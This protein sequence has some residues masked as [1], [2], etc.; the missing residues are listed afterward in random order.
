MER[1]L[2]FRKRERKRQ[3]EP[4][5]CRK[6]VL[7]SP[8]AKVMS[9]ATGRSRGQGS[10]KPVNLLTCHLPTEAGISRLLKL[11]GASAAEEGGVWPGP[12]LSGDG[13]GSAST[14]PSPC[15]LSGVD[16]G[17]PDSQSRLQEGNDRP[18]LRL[19]VTR[20]PRPTE[21]HEAQWSQRAGHTSPPVTE[22]PLNSTTRDRLPASLPTPATLWGQ[23]R[24][25]SSPRPEPAKSQTVW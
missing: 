3:K 14:A 17:L 24:D 22:L 13:G 7:P 18:D 15:L 21:R 2:H 16:E 4:R 9:T 23:T 12:C 8:W 19:V 1:R 5:E 20:G 25:G 10:G 11:R 6:T